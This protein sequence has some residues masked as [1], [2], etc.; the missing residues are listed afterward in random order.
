MPYLIVALGFYILS[1]TLYFLGE[2]YAVWPAARIISLSDRI[3]GSITIVPPMVSWF[4]MGFVMG[5]A[6]YFVIWGAH[7]TVRW[8]RRR[9]LW[10]GAAAAF[11]LIWTIIGPG[12]EFAMAGRMYLRPGVRNPYLGQIKTFQN[13]EFVWV[14]PGRFRMGS[15]SGAPGSDSDEQAHI[16]TL[17]RGFWLSRYEITQGQWQYVM[18]ST[19]FTFDEDVDGGL[20]DDLPAEG[21]DWEMAQKFIYTLNSYTLSKP[22]RLPTEA[23]WEYACRAGSTTAYSFGDSTTE[24]SNYAWYAGNSAGRPRK[25]GQKQPNAWGLYDMHGNVWEWCL[26][27]YGDYPTE[28]VV[29][30]FNGRTARRASRHTIRG[31]SWR[32][33]EEECRSARRFLFV[34]GQFKHP[35]DVGFRVLREFQPTDLN[36]DDS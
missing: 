33:G 25:V 26:D 18:E 7:R 29:D 2:E 5:A 11:I 12:L 24:L 14:P 21:I 17:T 23:E 28:R 31:G 4:I 3:L 15:V 32:T 6:V 35:D 1:R 16:V 22:F 9:M 19:P 8:R 13:I 36:E 30:P 10:I 27:Y 20:P 34:E